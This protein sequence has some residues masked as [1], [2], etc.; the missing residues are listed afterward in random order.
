MQPGGAL[1]EREEVRGG[2]G[3]VLL[4]TT[5]LT[6]LLATRRG[7]GESGLKCI[8]PVSL[9]FAVS[10]H[11]GTAGLTAYRSSSMPAGVID[12]AVGKTNQ[13]TKVCV[14]CEDA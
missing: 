11:G 4:T 14:S 10:P 7:A 8:G 12:R 2:P 13:E 1:P 5:A 3:S 9:C 6:P